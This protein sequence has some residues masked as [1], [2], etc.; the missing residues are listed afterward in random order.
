MGTFIKVNMPFDY[1]IIDAL[2]EQ[3]LKKKN[4]FYS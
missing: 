1:D 3:K 2:M 4:M